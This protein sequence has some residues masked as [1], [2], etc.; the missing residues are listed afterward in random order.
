MAH[1]LGADGC[2]GGW[3][4]IRQELVSGRISSEVYDSAGQLLNQSPK[5]MV[6]ALDIP[7]GLTDSGRRQCDVLARKMLGWPKGSSVFP[8][9]IR[10][11]L[12][13]A[14]RQDADDTTRGIDG[15]GVSAQAFGLYVRIRDVD[16]VIRGTERTSPY[17]YEVHPEVSF[18]AWN[19][20][21]PIV[22]SKK[23]YQGMSV[24]RGLIKS[25]FGEDAIQ[26]V[27]QR[28]PTS[29]VA[30]DDIYDAFATLWTAERIRLGIAKAIP[31]RPEVDSCGL[32]MAI[33]Y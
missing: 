14:N 3:I 28:H 22:E 17:V 11:A 4:T 19:G 13:A 6:L 30:D 7:I 15:R 27:R 12:K 25:H 8:A 21:K 26:L 23:S 31:D 18:M 1:I 32:P 20:G 2:R 9:P 29:A 5:P 16:G 24:R 33:W 10:P